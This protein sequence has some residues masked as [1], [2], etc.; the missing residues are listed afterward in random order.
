MIAQ[1]FS[2]R[3]NKIKLLQREFLDVCLYLKITNYILVRALRGYEEVII[4][5]VSQN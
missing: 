1:F 2:L 5:K 3:Y 4:G